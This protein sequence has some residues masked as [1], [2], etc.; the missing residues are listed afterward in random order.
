MWNRRHTTKFN[1]VSYPVQKAAAAVYTAEGQA[2]TK[3]LT[4][5][6]PSFAGKAPL[7]VYVAAESVNQAFTVSGGKILS[8]NNHHLRLGPI[9]TVVVNETLVGL[10]ANDPN[11]VIYHPEFKPDPAYMSN[12][13]FKFRDLIRVGTSRLDAPQQVCTT[14]K[15]TGVGLLGFIFS[16][17]APKVTTCS[18]PTYPNPTTAMTY[19]VGGAPAPAPTPAPITFPTYTSGST[20]MMASSSVENG[21]WGMAKMYDSLL[22]SLA[23]SM[24]WSSNSSP[25]TDHAEWVMIDK[26]AAGPTSY[27][28]LTPRTDG[29]NAGYGFPVDFRI[30]T[31]TDNVTWT[32]QVAKT[33]Y[34]KPAGS[35]QGFTFPTVTAR[36]V[37]IVGTKLRANPNDG[38]QYRMQLSELS[39][40]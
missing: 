13:G 4:D 34:A 23:A 25:A 10:M 24:G 36:Y 18:T 32:P 16:L 27:V 29:A 8:G 20:K 22:S 19:T 12:Y 33:G 37:R 14:S 9:S 28:N 15:P 38:N 39:C 2:Q 21:G 3:A 6:S 40:G 26:G 30:E 11:S 7:W 1:G 5:F 31:S 17:F 35:L